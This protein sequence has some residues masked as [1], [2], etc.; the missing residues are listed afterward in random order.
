MLDTAS[1]AVQ[2]AL[3]Q[4]P[5]PF[6]NAALCCQSAWWGPV[7]ESGLPALCSNGGMV[8]VHRIDDAAVLY[9]LFIKHI[10]K[11]PANCKPEAQNYQTFS[12]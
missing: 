10:E 9:I 8:Y 4:Y 2:A 12:I 3:P 7:A 5:E 11:S 1:A 6:L